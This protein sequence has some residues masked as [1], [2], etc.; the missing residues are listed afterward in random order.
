MAKTRTLQILRGTTV[1]NKANTGSAGELTMDITTNELRLHDGSTAGGH[2]I[3]SGG[4]GSG[5]HPDL[6]DVK[7]ADHICNDVQWLRADTFSWQSGAV[8]QAAYQHL[9]DDFPD[10]VLTITVGG[11]V[12]VRYSAN[13]V[14]GANHPYCWRYN[15]T[16]R[17][18]NS[19]TPSIGDFVFATSASGVDSGEIDSIGSSVP[20][21]ET[22]TIAG[23]TISY[24]EAADGHK[25]VL[26]DQESNVTAI[27]ASTGVAWY[28]IID[29]TNTR[30]KLPRTQF[31]FT[32]IRS[33]VGNY[34]EAGLPNI[35]GTISMRDSATINS[36]GAWTTK[37]GAFKSNTGN[38]SI[39]QASASGGWGPRQ[40]N[41]DFKASDS[42]SIYGNSNTVQPKATE[43]YL[44]F[45][46]GNFTQTAL[47]NTAGVTT[48]V[49][50]D[51]AD[52][53]FS[54]TTMID[55]VVEKQ[56]PTSSNNYTWY[57]KYK[58]G[59]VEQGGLNTQG[60]VNQRSA[61]LSIEMADGNYTVMLVPKR[62]GQSG[63][64]SAVGAILGTTATT[65][66]QFVVRYGTSGL[67][68]EDVL[69]QAS[70]MAA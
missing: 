16:D 48:E 46:V 22:E 69:W 32:G 1:Q 70:G 18:T 34:V 44:Y 55:Y 33:G 42:D 25:L 8:Y 14:P 35:T 41:I 21:P 31:A 39:V 37:T 12:Y 49:L 13:D 23:I 64:G 9:V 68:G 66:F 45:Y 28:Y 29:T 19:D 11:N 58:S 15:S 27:Y 38:Y 17:F 54:N 2:V 56:E 63:S 3:G 61:T 6:F 43:M 52:L 50:S 5:Y 65:G 20:L 26:P 40:G 10:N 57:R 53:D 24:Y 4:G 30:F 62:G 51:K 36:S 7:W 60:S 67:A 59:W 47:E